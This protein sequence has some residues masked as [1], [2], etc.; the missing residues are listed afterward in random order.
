MPLDDST[1]TSSE[2]D[3]VNV[4]PHVL[5][6]VRHLP[7]VPSYGS[8]TRTFQFVRAVAEIAD[9]SIVGAAHD[10][11][12]PRTEMLESFCRAMYVL[13]VAPGGPP[14]GIN[15]LIHRLREIDQRHRLARPLGYALDAA[16]A[17]RS[18]NAAMQAV[19]YSGLAARVSGLL[20]SMSYD[21]LIVEHTDIAA[22][23]LPV[24]KKFLIPCIA[25][26]HAVMHVHEQRA[27]TGRS[28]HAA[29]QRLE[30]AERQILDLYTRVIAVSDLD[31]SFLHRLVPSS[32]IEAIPTAVDAEYFRQTQAL[33]EQRLA[34]PPSAPTVVFTGLLTHEPNVDAVRWFATEIL[35]RI[36][37]KIPKTRV[38]VVGGGPL[39]R[40]LKALPAEA[41]VEFF[42]SV[43]DVRP[44]LA[45]ADVAIVPIRHGSGIRV[46]VMEA[47]AAGL[48]AVSTT[49][50]AEGMN[51][52][53]GRDLLIADDPATFATAV[54]H[55]LE[56][57][58]FG[59]QLAGHGRETVVKEYGIEAVAQR[60]Q[61]V[62][63]DVLKT[64]PGRSG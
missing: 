46:K 39:P 49:I 25:D 38:C 47:L 28:D 20:D 21:A 1:R 62:L 9:V 36:R 22:L 19:D 58:E 10:P 54:V 53:S 30:L 61:S 50:G 18:R 44:Y 24:V 5:F 29:V 13:P 51:F 15:N 32:A 56:R 48:P 6:V 23:L 52:E 16:S 57:P 7:Y 11:L 42:V 26:L 14:A 35:P 12:H 31:A 43:P 60:F 37:V 33:R 40:D 2:R 8:L 34:Q 63:R 3:G 17:L 64:S 59:R 4:R 27:Q 55:L 45:A 41:R